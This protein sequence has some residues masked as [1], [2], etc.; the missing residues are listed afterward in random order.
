[1]FEKTQ[2]AAG[3]R[4]APLLTHLKVLLD[5]IPSFAQTLHNGFVPQDVLLAQML[6]PLPGLEHQAV[7]G[8]EICQKVSHALLEE[9]Q[10]DKCLPA[11][12][13]TSCKKIN[14]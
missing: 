1:M 11:E 9:E 10:T 5:Q 2:P 7:D 4:L 6:T 12:S 8:V 14:K 13:P 3:G